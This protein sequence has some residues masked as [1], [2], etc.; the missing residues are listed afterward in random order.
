MRRLLAGPPSTRSE[1][2]EQGRQRARDSLKVETIPER[3]RQPKDKFI[4][5]TGDLT[6]LESEDKQKTIIKTKERT[7][8]YL[9]ASIAIIGTQP[10]QM[11]ST[12]SC[13]SSHG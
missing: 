2:E 4:A 6:T 13:L 10:L 11:T 8:T 12:T 9:L 3:K 5:F 7:G 1:G